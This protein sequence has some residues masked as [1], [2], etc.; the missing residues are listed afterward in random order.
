MKAIYFFFS[1]GHVVGVHMSKAG[2]LCFR[3]VSNF[4]VTKI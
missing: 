3:L 1:Y 4:P 2:Q